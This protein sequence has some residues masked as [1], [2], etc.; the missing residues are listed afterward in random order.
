MIECIYLLGFPENFG[1]GKVGIQSLSL[2]GPLHL[3]LVVLNKS[4]INLVQTELPLARAGDV[5][6]KKNCSTRLIL[7]KKTKEGFFLLKSLFFIKFNE[8]LNCKT[9][10]KYIG[11]I[12]LCIW[13]TNFCD[14]YTR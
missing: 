3:S 1:P 8:C 13:L 2:P 5:C 4:R 9:C 11:N 12:I 10:N 14:I 6:I 7:F